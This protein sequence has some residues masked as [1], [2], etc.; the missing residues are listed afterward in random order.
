MSK[1]NFL[2]VA[3]GAAAVLVAGGLF[4]SNMGFKLNYQLHG[5]G[6]S[7]L[8][9]L[10][11][12]ALPFNQQVG[13]NDAKNLIDDIN[14][15]TPASVLNVQKFVNTT[16]S[17]QVYNGT[18]GTAFALNPG[19]GYFVQMA[20]DVNYIVVGSHNPGLTVNFSG[21]GSSLTG[22]NF[23]ALPYH[24]NKTDAKQLIDEINANGTPTNQVL[25]AQK[26]VKTTNS[27]QVYNGTVGTAFSLN[28][29]EAFFVQMTTDTSFVP[30]HY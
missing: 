19:E 28:P 16:N 12:I 9:G 18:V 15:V 3:V 1:R 22:L 13:L 14:A 24:T 11:T 23:Y 2:V 17:F 29:G 7:S 26:F 25:N 8:T 30:S 27:F 10:N 21:P 20:T 4:A 6:A 5:P